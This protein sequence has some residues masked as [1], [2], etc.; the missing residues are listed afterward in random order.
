MTYVVAA[1]RSGYAAMVERLRLATGTE[2]LLIED[3]DKLTPERLE[4]L[5]PRQIFLPH[6]SHMVPAAIYEKF[7]CVVFHMT[8]LPF[9]RGGSPLQNLIVR[10]IRQTRLSAL[11]CEE[12][13]D[14]GPIYLKRDL[15]LEGTAEKIYARSARLVEEMILEIIATEPEPKPQQGEAVVFKRRQPEQSNLAGLTDP[16]KIY[17]HIR[18]LDAAGY[19]HAF[20]EIHGQR[21]EFTDAELKDGEV[22]AKVRFVTNGKEKPK[23]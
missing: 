9:G 1:S 11:R 15:S 20:L 14:A 7:E 23:K 5:Q 3:K 2:F 6:W 4:A 18:M 12:E 10:G 8:D 17:D 13:L 19:P 22:Q 21:L 16:R